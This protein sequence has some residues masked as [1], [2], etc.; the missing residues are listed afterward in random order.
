MFCKNKEEMNGAARIILNTFEEVS[1]EYKEHVN[2]NESPMSFQEFVE[3]QESHLYSMIQRVAFVDEMRAHYGILGEMEKMGRSNEDYMRL[4]YRI[5]DTGLELD[6]GIMIQGT[7][8]II[9]LGVYHLHAA[10]AGVKLNSPLSDR[11]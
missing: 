2:T 11:K 1:N 10:L 6:A 5:V 8:T 9:T 3:I 7:W 4:S